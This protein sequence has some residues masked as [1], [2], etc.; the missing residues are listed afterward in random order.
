MIIT[1][2]STSSRRIFAWFEIKTNTFNNSVEYK[3][4]IL[5]NEDH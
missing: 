4:I 1:L 3:I 2:I 5:K